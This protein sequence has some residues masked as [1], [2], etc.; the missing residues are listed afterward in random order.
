M[1]KLVKASDAFIGNGKLQPL[2]DNVDGRIMNQLRQHK[3]ISG[4]KRSYDSKG[5][6]KIAAKIV[7]TYIP[8]I[9][10]YELS[11]P[12]DKEIAV[13]LIWK[14]QIENFIPFGELQKI[15]ENLQELIKD[16]ILY[17]GGVDSINAKLSLDDGM[18]IVEANKIFEIEDNMSD[19]LVFCS[20]VKKGKVQ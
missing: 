13:K 15:V 11:E 4:I 19:D 17:L 16:D 20:F 12:T 1:F 5:N 10:E 6:L 2:K 9:K 3:T 14:K 8:L 7:E 18:L